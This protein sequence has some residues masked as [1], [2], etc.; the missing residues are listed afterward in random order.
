MGDGLHYDG[1]HEEHSVQF[2]TI[3]IGFCFWSTFA[4]S[5]AIAKLDLLVAVGIH[6]TAGFSKSALMQPIPS[7]AFFGCH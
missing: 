6:G 3:S 4:F 1:M 5:Q 7:A 2:K